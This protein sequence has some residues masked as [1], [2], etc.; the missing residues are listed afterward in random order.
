VHS[1]L[2]LHDAVQ[3]QFAVT[4]SMKLRQSRPSAPPVRPGFR[5][6]VPVFLLC[7][8]TW[9][10]QPGPANAAIH[11]LPVQGGVYML[12]GGGANIT[13]QTAKDGVLLVDTG[14]PQMAPQILAAIRTFS[15][16]PIR[17]VV[18]TNADGDH[19]GGNEA[20][21]KLGR[22]PVPVPTEPRIV[23]YLAVQE[24]L[25][26]PAPNETPVPGTLWPNDTY[27]TPY[28]DFFFNDEAIKV[29]HI[30]NA[31]TDGDSIVFFRRSDVLSVGDIFTPDRYPSIDLN[32]GGGVQGLIDGLNQILEITVPRKY[33][34]G[35][36]YVIPGHGRLCDEADVVEFRDMVTIIRDRVQD[37]IKKGMSLDQ[38]KAAKP[39]FDYDTQYSGS[40]DGFV[41]SI[42]KSLKK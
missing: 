41:E 37:L 3:L 30:P 17:W 31:H 26:E 39:S 34:E 22:S 10:Q 1:L 11:V 18:N 8:A 16:G 36:T 35:G 23:A 7:C 20:L 4:A 29:V 12:V 42:Y 27:S 19:I 2:H 14:V 9:A 33:Q 24:R 13:V 15:N 40:P 38:V 25:A 28:K 21:V 6:A 5:S 32:R